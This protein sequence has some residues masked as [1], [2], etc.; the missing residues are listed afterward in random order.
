MSNYYYNIFIKIM[1]DF[2]KNYSYLK[3]KHFTIGDL[4]RQFEESFKNIKDD[5]AFI[6][7][8]LKV[9]ELFEDIHVS[10]FDKKENQFYQGYRIKLDQNFD[11]SFLFKKYF[12]NHFILN[13]KAGLIGFY[14]DILYINFYTWANEF[15]SEIKDLLNKVEEKLKE[16]QIKKVIIDVR[17]NSGGND[18]LSKILLS[19]FI[20]KHINILVTKYLFRTDKNDCE[21]V[22]DAVDIF[23]DSHPKTY[24]GS[25]VCVLIGK[26]CMSSNEYM[27]NGFK[28]LRNF[29]EDFT[30]KIFLIGDNTFG[31]SGNPKE[32]EYESRYIIRI[33]SW[34]CFTPENELFE[35]VGVKPDI[36]IDSKKSIRFGKDKVF[37]KAL[38]VLK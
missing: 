37:E 26:S 5:E 27:I 12:N 24:S 23:Q 25:K 20:P 9:F 36:Y 35:G 22:G 3:Y 28:A 32:F 11:Y 21:K 17:S 8:L 18:G 31:S 10:L 19:Y 6:Y 38:E 34:I 13:N 4:I 14:K 16:K 7:L 29:N 1:N 2:Q 15:T 30:K 33:P